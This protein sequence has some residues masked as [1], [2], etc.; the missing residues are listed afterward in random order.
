M[1]GEISAN[2]TTMPLSNLIVIF[3][4]IIAVISIT[5]FLVRKLGLS[6]SKGT[7]KTS[8]YEYDQTC[9]TVMYHLQEVIE[10]VDYELR[11]SMRRQTKSCNYKI[12]KISCIEK[13]CQTSRRSLFYAF[14]DPFYE[15]INNNHFTR[16]LMPENYPSYRNQLLEMIREIHR[17]ILF[18]NT[19]DNCDKNVME[20]WNS[21]EESFQ[22]LIDDWLVMVM[23]E[24]RKSCAR[25]IKL[26]EA[27]IKN[28]EQSQHWSQV[29]QDCIEKNKYYI[30]VLDE[31]LKKS[32]VI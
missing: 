22:T 29:L 23:T 19:L 6:I 2:L 13:M 28:V 17:E 18:E 32:G 26:Y 21:V 3:V 12:S 4:G 10:S 5:L 31:R 24:V 27:E 15:Y 9:Q 25:K 11:C 8:D 7:L 1:Q 20:Q 14:K 30:Q 16:E